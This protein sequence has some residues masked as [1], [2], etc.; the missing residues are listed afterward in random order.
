MQM[1]TRRMPLITRA[2]GLIVAAAT[3][4]AVTCGA[5]AQDCEIREIVSANDPNNASDF[6]QI[7]FAAMNTS[8]QVVISITETT[9]PFEEDDISRIL[10]W[11]TVDPDADPT[12]NPLID[13]SARSADF[14][15]A[16]DATINDLGDIIFVGHTDA[17]GTNVFNLAKTPQLIFPGAPPTSI[18]ELVLLDETDLTFLYWQVGIDGVVEHCVKR[19]DSTIELCGSGGLI[20]VSPDGNNAGDVYLLRIDPGVSRQVINAAGVPICTIQSNGVL[21][22]PS[23]NAHGNVAF[24]SSQSCDGSGDPAGKGIYWYDAAAEQL[25]RVV[26]FTDPILDLSVPFLV[27]R[28]LLND[29]DRIAFVAQQGAIGR[30]GG[31]SMFLYSQ[32][33]AGRIL[34]LNDGADPNHTRKLFGY[35][36][37]PDD[38]KGETDRL[39]YRAINA[40]GRQTLFLATGCAHE[41]IAERC[42]GDLNGD[43]IVDGGD[44]LILL[45]AWGPNPG[46]PA[47]LN[48]D[49]TVDGGDLLI[50]LSAWGECPDI[51]ECGESG[52]GDCCEPKVSNSCDDE[53]CCEFVCGMD[54]FCCDVAWDGYC[55]AVANEHCLVCGVPAECGVVGTGDCCV[56]QTDSPFCNDADCCE[57]ICAD[58]AFC[59]NVNWD[60]LCAG[61][62]NAQC[63]VCQA[64]CTFGWDLSVGLPGLEGGSVADLAVFDGAL[65]AAGWFTSAGGQDAPG[66]AWWDGTQWHVPNFTTALGLEDKPELF[67]EGT[68]LE[69]TT[70]DFDE[71]WL[72]FSLA[73]SYFD[74][75]DWITNAPIAV[76]PSLSDEPTL[77]GVANDYVLDIQVMP[78]GLVYVAGEFTEIDGEPMPL[79][80]QWK[81]AWWSPLPDVDPTASIFAL[82]A[83][84][85]GS[86]HA[87][88]FSYHFIVPDIG[89]VTIIGRHD[90]RE[91]T[92]IASVLGIVSAM[93]VV[94]GKL[95][96]GGN[97]SEIDPTAALG[98][99]GVRGGRGGRGAL[100]NGVIPANNVASWDGQTWEALGDGTEF[101]IR[102]FA[103]FDDGEGEMLYATGAST[104]SQDP[105]PFIVR[106][107]GVDWAPINDTGPNSVLGGGG[108]ALG[109]FQDGLYVGGSFDS[110]FVKG[111]NV[112]LGVPMEVVEVNRIAAWRCVED[113]EFGNDR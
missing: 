109:V 30:S 2:A 56:A 17:D 59:C 46:H 68:A 102:D 97:F 85:D 31:F 107:D 90:E 52:S 64:E 10:L 5:V 110:I 99:R 83:Y 14:N 87:L 47:D 7:N 26:D 66:I 113:V 1:K 74:G 11:S 34:K 37:D 13:S 32:A 100:G 81:G 79:L 16:I 84:D 103:V 75:A 92:E 105:T 80:A 76:I 9:D 21:T 91:L 55:A 54:P 40:E 69:V 3:T 50:L 27:P 63:E 112:E 33:N 58:D 95:I 12:A 36:V 67:I 98:G 61:A 106:W 22:G 72:I 4:V 44:L 24:Y 71:E 65:V 73:V 86:G 78:S 96:I 42:P 88:Y 15:F 6:T 51:F 38:P 77:I 53:E 89:S 104:L 108:L 101:F 94:D 82:E 20:F 111:E 29:A 35:M 93:T 45:S 25:T 18:G 60:S 8:G 62:A 57:L 41:I 70:N 39:L 19:N 49:G 43:G 23:V 28:P 48:G